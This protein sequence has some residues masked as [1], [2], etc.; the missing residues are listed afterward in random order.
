MNIKE[1]QRQA[2][3]Y[4]KITK[5]CKCGHSVVMPVFI[6]KKNMQSLWKVSI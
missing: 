5:K 4:S 6:D 2:D 3:Y 1:A